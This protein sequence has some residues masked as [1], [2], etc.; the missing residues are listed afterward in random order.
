MNDTT[1]E[2]ALRA[3]AD[4]ATPAGTLMQIVSAHPEL[5]WQA[6]DHPNAYPDLVAWVQQY[7]PRTAPSTTE[8][9][10]EQRN[11]ARPEDSGPGARTGQKKK[12]GLL[13]GAL[14][15]IAVIVIG[16][17]A[18]GGTIAWNKAHE[19]PAT[20]P[21]DG[22]DDN[23]AADGESAGEPGETTGEGEHGSGGGEPE[24]HG[25]LSPDDTTDE[26]EAA[27]ERNGFP[28]ELQGTWCPEDSDD[29]NLCFNIDDWAAENADGF[30]QDVGQANAYFPQPDATG[31]SLCLTDDT[32]SG[33]CSIAASML[34]TYYPVGVETN[35]C[36]QEFVTEGYEGCEPGYEYDTSRDRLMIEANHQ[37]DTVF[38]EA[39][40]MYRR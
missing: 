10:H 32:G 31:I 22:E 20:T 9:A 40:P 28:V 24:S 14:V 4:P 13:I 34:F 1:R 27:A 17:G 18:I 36:D 15:A 16:G 2:A 38:H 33:S 7:S 11:R 30:V 3:L 5:G 21:D 23:G 26:L 8:T 29:P 39:T 19:T 35:I 6:A 37:Q 25:P 12:R